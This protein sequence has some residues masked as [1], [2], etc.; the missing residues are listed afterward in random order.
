MDNFE[1]RSRQATTLISTKLKANEE[2]TISEDRDILNMLS[3]FRLPR[4]QSTIRRAYMVAEFKEE[5]MNDVIAAVHNALR[6]LA[7]AKR[8]QNFRRTDRTAVLQTLL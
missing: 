4:L 7:T 6:K 5:H 2:D 3:R 8:V 1:E